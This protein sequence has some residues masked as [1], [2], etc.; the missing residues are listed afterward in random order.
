MNQRNRS[1]QLPAVLVMS[2]PFLLV[3]VL[4]FALMSSGCSLGS[5]GGNQAL[6]IVFDAPPSLPQVVAAINDNS[7]RVGQLSSQ[8][9]R[10]TVPGQLGSLTATINY[11]RSPNP[12][13]PGLF[14]LSGEAL[15]RKQLDLGSNSEH[16]WMWVKQNQPP[17]VFWGRHSEFYRSAAQQVLPMP[18]SWMVEAM[19]VVTIDPASVS[20]QSPYAST[21]PGLLQIRSLIPTPQGNLTRVLEVDQQRG[22]IVQQQIYDSTNRLLAVADL[23]N[24]THDPMS[25]VTLPRTIRIQLP[26]AGLKFN[27]EVDSY[28]VNALTDDPRA[29]WSMPD[30]PGHALLDLA[31]PEHMRGINLM[32]QSADIYNTAAAI[33]TPQRP[34]V[35]A[36]WLQLPGLGFLR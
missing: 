34:E 20:Q 33:Q 30:F 4:L 26:P 29:L 22:V 12:A 11:E 5:M 21:T 28:N 17:T 7:Q 19:G 1:F 35:R 36:A 25:G 27:F 8:N 15:G 18:P 6:P 2:K 32:G 10:L 24:F 3:A 23:A 13:A 31:N 16:Y 14:R 9:V